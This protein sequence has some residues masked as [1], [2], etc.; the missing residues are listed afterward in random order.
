[1]MFVSVCVFTALCV[2]ADVRDV[3]CV[4]VCARYSKLDL[5]PN[6]VIVVTVQYLGKPRKQVPYADIV[7]V[8]VCTLVM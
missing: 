5:T 1:M 2:R 3:Y 6:S 4:C 7:V 8:D